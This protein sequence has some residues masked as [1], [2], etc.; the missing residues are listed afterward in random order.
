MTGVQTCALPISAPKSLSD[1]WIS[2]ARRTC[3]WVTAG[4][5]FWVKGSTFGEP[6]EGSKFSLG[7]QPH[8][9]STSSEVKTSSNG[10]VPDEA[11]ADI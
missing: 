11:L 7:K 2:E 3:V 4:F 8:V 1:S 10:T 6:S 9:M 5:T